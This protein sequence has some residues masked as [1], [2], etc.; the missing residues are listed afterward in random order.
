[1]TT[2]IKQSNGSV[3]LSESKKIVRTY[4]KASAQLIAAATNYLQAATCIEI[5]NYQDAAQFS[6]LANEYLAH[7]KKTKQNGKKHH[8]LSKVLVY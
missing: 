1:M 5:G 4:R 8:L 3:S 2:L 7:A 6:L